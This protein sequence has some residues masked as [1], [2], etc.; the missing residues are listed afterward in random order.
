[1]SYQTTEVMLE[2]QSS[3]CL[4]VNPGSLSHPTPALLAQTKH[5]FFILCCCGLLQVLR[6]Q[7]KMHLSED[8]RMPI[9][10]PISQV[11]GV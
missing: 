8:N 4:Q 10:P 5:L 2:V 6:A 11:K 7:K 1:M 3:L 9:F